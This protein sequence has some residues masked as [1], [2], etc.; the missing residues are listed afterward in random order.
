[1]NTLHPEEITPPNPRLE[2]V[3]VPSSIVQ[4]A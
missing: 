3:K 1:M 4:A 2:I